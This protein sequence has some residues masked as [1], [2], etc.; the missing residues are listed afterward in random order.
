[1][2][3]KETDSTIIIKTRKIRSAVHAFM[4]SCFHA[5]KLLYNTLGKN[6][7]INIGLKV[8]DTQI[9]LTLEYWCEVWYRSK[10]IKLIQAVYNTYIKRVLA[11]KKKQ[12]TKTDINTG[13]TAKL[14]DSRLNFTQNSYLY[15]SG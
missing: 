6:I 9:R 7:P 12:K 3:P 14:V 4:L 5:N 15:L 11:V 10:S 8:F 2:R 13:I 1:M